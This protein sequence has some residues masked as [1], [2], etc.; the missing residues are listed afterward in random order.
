MAPSSGYVVIMNELRKKI[1]GVILAGGRSRRFGSDKAAVIIADS[2]SRT[3]LQRICD[4][5]KSLQLDVVVVTHADATLKP[6]GFTVLRDLVPDSGPL[7]GIVTAM[8]LVPADAY[9]V[10]TCDMPFVTRDLLAQLVAAF[11]Q[12]G[13]AS[14]FESNFVL[15]PFPALLTSACLCAANLLIAERRLDMSGF[16][17][18]ISQLHKV[19]RV[20]NGTDFMNM[21]TLDDLRQV[22]QHLPTQ[23]PKEK[24]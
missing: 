10:V 22:R 13:M 4:E 1:Q 23:Q 17:A 24:E 5:L 19:S 9:L 8:T 15:Q 3:L 20:D 7:G 6:D 21:N 11:Q 16:L 18:Q 12:T 14:V 2:D